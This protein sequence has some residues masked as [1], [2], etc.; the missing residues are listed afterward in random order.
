[1]F[2]ILFKMCFSDCKYVLYFIQLVF[3]AHQRKGV[4]T[5]KKYIVYM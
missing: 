3:G 5:N 1:L 2:F 4:I